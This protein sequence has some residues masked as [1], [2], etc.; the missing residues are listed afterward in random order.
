MAS[1]TAFCPASVELFVPGVFVGNP[2][3]LVGIGVCQPGAG[4]TGVSPPGG[5]FGPVGE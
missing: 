5:P 2:Q 1:T 3:P 4:P